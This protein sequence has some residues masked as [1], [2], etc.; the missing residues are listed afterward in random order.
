MNKINLVSLQFYLFLYIIYKHWIPLIIYING[1][2][3]HGGIHTKYGHYLR[4]YDIICN[5]LLIYYTTI[6]SYHQKH[7]PNLIYTF[8]AIIIS[9]INKYKFNDNQFI[10]VFGVHSFLT[11]NLYTYLEYIKRDNIPLIY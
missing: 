1:I 4:N 5:L 7:I 3:F 2:L 10:H 9:Q 6:S 11:Y 8:F